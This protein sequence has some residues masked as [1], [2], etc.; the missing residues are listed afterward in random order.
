MR[1]RLRGLFDTPLADELAALPSFRVTV[2]QQ[3][4]N[5]HYLSDLFHVCGETPAEGSRRDLTKT[6][7][8]DYVP[9]QQRR[10]A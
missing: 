10:E 1:L 2:C 9:M 5:E 7:V 3:C 8:P 6:R 4:G